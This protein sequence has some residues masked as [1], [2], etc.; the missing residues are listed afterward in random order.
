MDT[1]KAR[2]SR[3]LPEVQDAGMEQVGMAN[4]SVRTRDGRVEAVVAAPSISAAVAQAIERL[5]A[6]VSDRTVFLRGPRPDL[7]DWEAV[8]LPAEGVLD[9]R[10][11]R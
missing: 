4:F 11:T 5:D 3:G 1:E 7:L 9:M 6:M 8:E 2:A 10:V